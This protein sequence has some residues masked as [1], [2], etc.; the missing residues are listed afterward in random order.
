[1]NKTFSLLIFLL[2]IYSYNVQSQCSYNL[3]NVTH[4]DC[5]ND[6]TGKIDIS[7]S[8]P[9]LDW[10]WVFPNS[11]I[12]TSTTIDN[13]QAG[14]YAIVLNEYFIPGDS[15]S[16]LVCSI[17][18]TITVE[19]TIQITADFILKNNC[20][21][22]DSTDVIT[23]IY[24]GTSPYTTIWVET[25]DTEPNTIN[26]APSQTPYTFSITDVNGCQRSEF[27]WV[28]EVEE[29]TTYMSNEDVICKDDFS[30]TA[31]VFVEN[32]TPPF[33]FNWSTGAEFM[34]NN[35]CSIHDLYP[36]TYYVN[37][38]DTMGCITSDTIVITTDPKNCITI[39][40]V[41]SPNFD[42]INDY[43]EIKNI[44]LYPEALIEVY[45]RIGNIVYR[46]RNYENSEQIAFNGFSSD[47]KELP[48]GTYYY[49]LNLENENEVLKGTL[50]IK[51]TR[52]N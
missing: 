34:D 24:G 39:Y 28:N 21:V 51:R 8:N 49:V 46:R 23:S 20:N 50:T 31:R 27:L 5:H 1:M 35:A 25:G 29:M 7:I 18:D 22:N 36:G 2:S 45:D 10:N 38:R 44:H 14:K 48:S 15:T 11:T 47:G 6:N 42:G 26:L 17:T 9:N 4:I 19:Q 37:I 3:V 13:L 16:S 32:G 41:F 43:W 40:K 12:S 33:V 30:G 52:S